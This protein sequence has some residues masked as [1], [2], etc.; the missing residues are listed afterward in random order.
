MEFTR[1][2]LTT[3]NSFLPSQI[4]ENEQLVKRLEEET[5]IL[6]KVDSWYTKFKE[7][8]ESNNL[9]EG[10]DWFEAFRSDGEKFYTILTQFLF[11]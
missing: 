7:Y 5:S 4:D 2:P 1:N 8:T 11:R 9:L 6:S 10:S 3:I